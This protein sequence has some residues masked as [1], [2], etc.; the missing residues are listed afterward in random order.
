MNIR[1]KT[2]PKTKQRYLATSTR[3]RNLLIDPFANKGSAYSVQER[4]ALGLHGLIPAAVSNMEEQLARCY[5]NYQANETNLGKFIYLS[6]LQDRNETLFYRLV[7]DHIDE[8][9][10]IVYTPVVG[11]ACQKYSHIYRRAR[12]LYISY[13]ERHR[14]TEVLA[15]YGIDNPS[16]IV[17]TDGERVLGLGDQG[18]GGLGI[19]IGKLVLYTLCAGIPPYT[20]IP[21]CLDVGTDNKDRLEDKL[22]LGL[23]KKRV[24]GDKYQDF[25]DSF[26]N[27]VKES[28]PNTLLQW[29]DFLKANAIKQLK[30]FRDDLCTF[31]DDI[32]GTAAVT[33][34]GIYAGLRKTGGRLRDQRIVIAGAGASAQGIA[35]LCVIALGKDGA[36]EAEAQRRIWTCDSRG[37]VTRARANLEE[38]KATYARPVEEIA[39]YRCRDR[40]RITLEETVLNSEP[41]ILI[42]VSAMRGLFTENIVKL[43]ARFNKTPLIFALSNPTSECECTPADVIAW[44]EGRAL[45]ATGSP[46]APVQYGGRTIRIGQSNNAFI[47]PGVGLGVW[48]GQC[49]RISDAMFLDAA[50]TL[51]GLT[52]ASDLDSG[53]LFPELTRIRE[54]SHAVACAVVR[55]AV[56]EG[57]AS[58]AAAEGI[59]ER[60]RQEMWFPEYMPI[61]YEP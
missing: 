3:G 27:A 6:G 12:G 26:V 59:E 30:K 38:F 1:V 22:Y 24:R 57:N 11:E 61:K 42:G 34:A 33:L 9:M 4:T 56:A 60:I 55:R 16:I 48:V 13:N 7:H 31:N 17:V 36:P 52:S 54:I 35:N 53:A 25:V 45:V 10:P 19:C 23:N 29:E 15:N 5:E 46:F 39:G 20:A 37:L 44:T 41:T 40:E 28:Y 47:F 43:T 18:A 50:E 32:Q 2:D 8:M 49:R 51:A 21:I 58:S 14:M